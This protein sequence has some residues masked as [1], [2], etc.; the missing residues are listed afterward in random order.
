MAIF[1]EIAAHSVDHMFYLCFDFICNFSNFIISY[2]GFE[3]WIWV[4]VASVPGFCM[5]LT[6]IA[7]FQLILNKT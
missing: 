4:L 5:L 6:Y 1:R 2:F 3:G 7:M